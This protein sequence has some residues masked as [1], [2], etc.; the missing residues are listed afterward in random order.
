MRLLG[1]GCLRDGRLASVRLDSDHPAAGVRG[2]ERAV[3][4]GEDAFRPLE[5]PP[6]LSEGRCVDAEVTDRVAAHRW[7]PASS[8]FY[9]GVA[10]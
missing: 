8:P 7:P 1:W 10:P 2:P 9:K 5:V 3:G 6:Y 4:L